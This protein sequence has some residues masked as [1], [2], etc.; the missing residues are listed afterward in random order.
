MK[1]YIQKVYKTRYFWSH[2]AKGDLQ[3]RFR[4]SKLGVLWIIAQPFFLT[5]I[6]SV[7]FSTVFQQELGEYLLYILSGIVVWDLLTAS[8][9]GGSNSILQSEQ[10]IRQFNHP[11]SIYTLRFGVLNIV[12]FLIELIA[13]V[14]WCVCTRP[15]TLLMAVITLPGTVIIYFILSW[16]LVTIAGYSNTKYRDYPQIMTLLMQ[17]LWYVSPV[18]FKEELFLTNKFLIS[19]FKWNPITHI[20]AL[21][22]NPFLFG[23]MPSFENYIFSINT[24]LIICIWAYLVNRK[25]EKKII[26]YL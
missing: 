22:R 11:I 25:N 14:I 3:S 26:F 10:Y 1:S 19:M 2:L 21:I 20:L 17:A 7:V 23:K 13:L 6:M 8:I 12:T 15:N 18:F 5:I 4:R 16:A 24:V 9:I